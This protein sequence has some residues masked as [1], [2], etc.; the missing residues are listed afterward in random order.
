[1]FIVII[2]MYIYIFVSI[3]KKHS[4]HIMVGQSESSFCEQ[5]TKENYVLS[6]LKNK[7]DFYVLSFITFT[8][9]I[10]FSEEVTFN[11]LL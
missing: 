10:S 5:K 4:V 9:H 1:M 8:V 3:L 11:Y 2:Y 6:S 7:K